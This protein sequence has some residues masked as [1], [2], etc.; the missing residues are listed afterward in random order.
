MATYLYTGIGAGKTTNSLGLALRS[1]GHGHR[2]VIIQF[3]KGRK[4]IGECLF[5]EKIGELGDKY[6][7]YQYG[8]IGFVDLDNPSEEDKEKAGEGL[9]KAKNVLNDPPHLLILDEINLAVS[10]GLLDED[11]NTILPIKMPKDI[12]AKKGINY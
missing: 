9:E 8:R 3:M 10:V 2:V 12:T 1:L 7:I 4:D 11:V 6:E 5:K